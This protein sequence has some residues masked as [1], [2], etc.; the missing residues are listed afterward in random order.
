MKNSKKAM[1]IVELFNPDMPTWDTKMYRQK[2]KI[3]NILNDNT[4]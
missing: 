1:K 4:Q 3:L 2:E